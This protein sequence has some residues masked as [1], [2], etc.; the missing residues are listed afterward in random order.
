MNQEGSGGCGDCVNAGWVNI[1]YCKI[2]WRRKNESKVRVEI[3]RQETEDSE[4]CKDCMTMMCV[5]QQERKEDGFFKMYVSL[6][7]LIIKL[8]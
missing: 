5:N 3:N 1:G 4:S 7:L 2:C 6:Y 8:F